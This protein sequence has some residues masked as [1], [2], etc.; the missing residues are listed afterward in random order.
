M[1]DDKLIELMANLWVTCGGDSTG[2][3]CCFKEILRK[4]KELNFNQ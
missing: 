1:N 2:F 4:I 3:E